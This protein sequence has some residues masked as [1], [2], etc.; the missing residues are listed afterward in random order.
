MRTLTHEEIE[1]IDGAAAPLVWGMGLGAVTGAYTGY[2][3]GGIS[4]AFIGGAFG[5]VTGGAVAMAT[6][7]A[8]ISLAGRGMF[9]GY[10]ILNDWMG[11]RAVSLS[12]ES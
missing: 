9:A 1:Q 2:Q 12:S 8:G 5:V 6:M 11:G 10:G 4:G 3:E 7:G